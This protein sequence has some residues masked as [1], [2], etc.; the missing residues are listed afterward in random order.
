M[1]YDRAKGFAN[2]RRDAGE[3]GFIHGLREIGLVGQRF[4]LAVVGVLRLSHSE[5]K[6]RA[7]GYWD[8][9]FS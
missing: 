1:V 6:H 5:M 8:G 4:V 3:W 2:D 9:F 7:Y